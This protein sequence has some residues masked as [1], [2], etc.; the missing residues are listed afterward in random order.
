VKAMK[1]MKVS[2]IYIMLLFLYSCGLR[3]DDSSSAITSI[4][5]LDV[6][7]EFDLDVS[8]EFDF[9]GGDT[10]TVTVIDKSSSIDRR[11]LNV[12]SDFSDD[13]GELRVNYESCLLRTSLQG[14]YSEFK[15]VVSSNQ[16]EFIAQIWPFQ[17]DA[18]S[19]NYRWSRLEDSNDWE[20]TLH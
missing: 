11:Y 19:I 16:R 10:L 12:C 4:E 1:A 15:I 7:S 13:N 20:I 17:N 3:E 5:D 14:Q 18:L 9:I 8:S 6:S 2:T